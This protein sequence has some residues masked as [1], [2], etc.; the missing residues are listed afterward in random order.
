[1][2][3]GNSMKELSKVFFEETKTR[4]LLHDFEN[5]YHSFNTFN[6][7]FRVKQHN[8]EEIEFYR[9]ELEEM[10]VV[11]LSFTDTILELGKYELCEK[12]SSITKNIIKILEREL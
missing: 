10:L 7:L 2:E 3:I 6:N 4:F 5:A 11:S 8:K 1:M 9:G 12:L